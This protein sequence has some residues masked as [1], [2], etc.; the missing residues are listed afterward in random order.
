MFRVHAPGA[1]RFLRLKLNDRDPFV[2]LG[3]ETLVG[4][5]PGHLLC[6]F[7]HARGP[8]RIF[9]LRPWNQAGSKYSDNHLF[10]QS[11]KLSGTAHH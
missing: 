5:I 4:N 2:V 7:A 8:V 3:H 11:D 10:L 1:L 9:L 6:Q